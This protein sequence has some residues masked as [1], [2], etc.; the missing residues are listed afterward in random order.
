MIVVIPAR[1]D[2]QRLP[3]KLLLSE[4]GKPLIQHVYESV[5]ETFETYVATP[6]REIGDAVSSFGGQRP[7]LLGNTEK[8]Q[9]G[10]LRLWASLSSGKQ[11]SLMLSTSK[12]TVLYLLRRLRWF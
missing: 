10:W 7:L 6:D 12:V 2:S 4:T 8:E 1:L 5:A 3:R 11:P 9:T